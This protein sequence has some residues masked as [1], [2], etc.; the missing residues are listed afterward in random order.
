MAAA[1]ARHAGLKIPP[2][3]YPELE[4]YARRAME[5]AQAAGPDEYADH[6]ET[7]R[8]SLTR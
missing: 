4:A 3:R 8:L 1:L 5:R 7:V 6:L 2:H